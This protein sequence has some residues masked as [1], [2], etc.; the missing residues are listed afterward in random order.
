MHSLENCALAARLL[1]NPSAVR[2][3]RTSSAAGVK[4]VILP[5]LQT[6]LQT[7]PS[8]RSHFLGFRSVFVFVVCDFLV[9]VAC[10]LAQAK[11]MN[12]PAPCG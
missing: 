7:L 4:P 5:I 3:L 1:L 10:L 12:C 9:I 11:A 2:K 6:L 8:Q